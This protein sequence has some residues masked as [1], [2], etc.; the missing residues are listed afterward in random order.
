MND[1]REPLRSRSEASATTVVAIPVL[2]ASLLMWGLS[3]TVVALGVGR[4]VVAL[5]QGVPSAAFSLRIINLDAEASLPSWYSSMQLLLCAVLLFLQ[6]WSALSQGSKQWAGWLFLAVGFVLMS[7]DE[8]SAIHEILGDKINEAIRPAGVFA[9][10]WV[11]V[12]IP[13]VGGVAL[14]LLRF[15]LLLP[16]ATL[17]LFLASGAVYVLG[18]VG[19]EM[20]GAKV[21]EVSGLGTPSYIM[22]VVL[23]ETL[24]IFG[25]TLFLTSLLIHA[26][27]ER[28]SW[29]LQTR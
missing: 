23:E 20:V 26:H 28:Q 9:F 21:S 27:R 13:L 22:V 3:A 11:L 7:M 10:G 24:E 17:L 14:L 4:E 2:G 18:A 12:A 25:I 1:L 16:R 8:G 5:I 6:S 29:L 19:F 15:L